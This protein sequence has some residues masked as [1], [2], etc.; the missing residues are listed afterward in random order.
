MSRQMDC[1]LTDMLYILDE[2]SIGLH[3]RDTQNLLKILFRLKEKGN[4]V[5]VVEHDPDIIRAAEWIVDI[6]PGAGKEGGTVV[7]NG[8]PEGLHQTSGATA[9]YLY[10]KP[11]PYYKRKT[12]A[13]F[14]EITNATVNN[15]K[16]IVCAHTHGGSH[17]YSGWPAAEKA[18]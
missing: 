1:N 13:D 11:E 6:G 16:N 9:E 2:P 15:L 4:S 5:Y 3:P 14:Y 18:A 8:A 12:A 7:Y 17:M 10:R